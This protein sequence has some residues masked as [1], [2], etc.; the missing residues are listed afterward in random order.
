MR[1]GGDWK[2]Q[3]SF[4]F[5]ETVGGGVLEAARGGEV[6]AAGLVGG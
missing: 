2:L 3:S 5:V 1:A 6:G 4:Q